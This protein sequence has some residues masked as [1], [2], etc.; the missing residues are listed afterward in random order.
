MVTH[1]E[2]NIGE[3]QGRSEQIWT[4]EYQSEANVGVEETTGLFLQSR[5]IHL[6]RYFHYSMLR[7]LSKAIK[8][9]KAS[10]IQAID[11]HRIATRLTSRGTN[12]YRKIARFTHH[13]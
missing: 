10:Y 13:V 9:D 12:G 3:D 4:A 11:Y 1:D 7:V 5:R 8:S 6:Y 2:T